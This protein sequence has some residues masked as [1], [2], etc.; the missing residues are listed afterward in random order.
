MNNYDI[1][2]PPAGIELFDLSQAWTSLFSPD[3]LV[4]QDCFLCRLVQY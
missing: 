3:G 2:P 1:M 4:E